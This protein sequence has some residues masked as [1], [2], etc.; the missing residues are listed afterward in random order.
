MSR[1]D[2]RFPPRI[3]LSNESKVMAKN[4]SSPQLLHGV[5]NLIPTSSHLGKKRSEPYRASCRALVSPHERAEISTRVD[6]NND[7]NLCKKLFYFIHYRVDYQFGQTVS[8]NS[9]TKL[10]SFRPQTILIQDEA[11]QSYSL[12]SLQIKPSV[13]Q[14]PADGSSGFQKEGF[15]TLLSFYKDSTTKQPSQLNSKRG[16]QQY[17][18]SRMGT[19]QSAGNLINANSKSRPYTVIV[20]QN[21]EANSKLEVEEDAKIKGFIEGLT[22]ALET[23]FSANELEKNMGKLL[24]KRKEDFWR[25]MIDKRKTWQD[26]G[27]IIYFDY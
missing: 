23:S 24:N 16:E 18:K 8:I 3:D 22:A 27:N 12:P 1:K 13:R 4:S 25:E 14:T 5:E 15:E 9:L 26:S 20:Q 21:V 11:T 7:S 6:P 2:R 10:R 17:D 19:S